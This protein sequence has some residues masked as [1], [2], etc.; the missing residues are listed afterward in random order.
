MWLKYFFATL[1]LSLTSAVYLLSSMKAG[2][3]AYPRGLWGRLAEGVEEADAFSPRIIKDI[4]P[5]KAFDEEILDRL[6]ARGLIAVSPQ[7]APGA[8]EFYED[9]IV[10]YDT[11]KVLWQLLPDVPAEG[12]P[13]FIREVEERLERREHKTW[14]DEWPQLWKKIAG[15]E[16]V[17]FL[18]YTLGR[19]DF[20]YD[21]DGQATDLFD[22]L[23][24]NYSLAQ[25]FKHIDKAT[26][27]FADFARRQRWPM[28]AGRAVEQVRS[29]VEFYRSKG[30]EI[31][32]F[33][34]R[35]ASPARSVIS[36]IFFDS[37]LGVGADYFFKAPK[38]VDLPN[39]KTEEEA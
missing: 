7:S 4:S 39:S 25:V 18:I 32:A 20:S 5:T 2:G 36:N 14:R 33:H 31:F 29:N 35:P 22:S 3:P 34:Y 17:Q 8:F 28:R 10:G 19:Y 21:P 6:K 16:C 13:S 15:A 24:D 38:D 12:R 11:E 9:T 1:P 26:K 23:V 37:V 27:D 30:W